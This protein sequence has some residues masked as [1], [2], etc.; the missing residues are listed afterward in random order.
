LKPSLGITVEQIK[1]KIKGENIIKNNSALI[2]HEGFENLYVDGSVIIQNQVK[3]V[4][5]N[6]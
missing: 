3:D 1:N 6:N 5:I 4:K 2:I